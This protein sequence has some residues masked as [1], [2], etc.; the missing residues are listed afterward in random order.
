MARE[1]S[2]RLCRCLDT[3]LAAGRR[4]LSRRKEHSVRAFAEAFASGNVAVP[5][6]KRHCVVLLLLLLV[7]LAVVVAALPVLSP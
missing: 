1:A 7:E 6:V 3:H 5:T 2:K 4:S